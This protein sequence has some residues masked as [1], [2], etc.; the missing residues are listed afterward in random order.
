MKKI[1]TLFLLSLLVNQKINAQTYLPV[2]TTGYTLDAVA[3]NTTAVLYT[4][5]ALDAGGN[6]FFSKAYG[7]IYSSIYGLPNN[8]VISSATRT[9]QLQ[10]YTGP[11]AFYLPTVNQVDSL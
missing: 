10:S 8:G 1:I 9:Y 3:E 4:T 5:G 11:N 6:C 7:A 2:A